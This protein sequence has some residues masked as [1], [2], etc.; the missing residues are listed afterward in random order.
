MGDE[1]SAK[2]AAET[3]LI[4]AEVAR[5]AAATA[6]EVART[7]AA[8][9]AQVASE[10]LRVSQDVRVLRMWLVGDIDERT[11]TPIS[12]A[13][14]RLESLEVRVEKWDAARKWVIGAAV[15]V[16]IAAAT[17][18]ATSMATHIQGNGVH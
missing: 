9:A 6:A 12:G 10:V 14:G 4:A 11:G 16:I 18:G 13:L 3:A 8:Q 1:Q 15:S 7:V 5:V 2:N 17:S